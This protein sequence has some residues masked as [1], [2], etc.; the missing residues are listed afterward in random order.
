MLGSPTPPPR[1]GSR[2]K[3]YVK[4]FCS[5]MAS[6]MAGLVVRQGHAD[7]GASGIE[8]ARCTSAVSE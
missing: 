6:N 2:R 3:R 4:F 1:D 8:G 5:S 7:D